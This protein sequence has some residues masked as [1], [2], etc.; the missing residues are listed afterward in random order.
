MII[1]FLILVNSPHPS[2]AKGVFIISYKPHEHNSQP[3]ESKRTNQTTEEPK[4]MQNSYKEQ[5]ECNSIKYENPFV[6]PNDN[7]SWCKNW[8]VS[9]QTYLVLLQKLAEAKFKREKQQFVP[10]RTGR[11]NPFDMLSLTLKNGR[12]LKVFCTWGFV[13][14]TG[15]GQWWIYGLG[16]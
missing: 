1:L 2:Q 13:L 3:H 15:L 5:G 12:T 7:P 10:F 11:L 4:Y 6:Y 9:C 16:L 8:S 14:V